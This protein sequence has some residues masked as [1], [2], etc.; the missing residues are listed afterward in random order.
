MWVA[1]RPAEA[2]LPS[3]IGT[4]GLI[5]KVVPIEPVRKVVLCAGYRRES[6]QNLSM[7][8][9]TQGDG[10]GHRG[11]KQSRSCYDIKT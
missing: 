1:S 5:A 9:L 10:A 6:G 4:T 11:G 8:T 3:R 7:G 2:C